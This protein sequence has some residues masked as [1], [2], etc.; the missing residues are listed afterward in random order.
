MGLNVTELQEQ[1]KSAF[2]KA[3]DTPA[4]DDSADAGNV[5]NAILAR[6]A[7]DLASAFDAYVRGGDVVGIKAKVEVDPE[8]GDLVGTQI[9][10][11]S[12]R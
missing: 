7:A 3:K 1:I 2:E 11:G 9:G 6:L 5:Q 10:T 12:I 8:T 4:P